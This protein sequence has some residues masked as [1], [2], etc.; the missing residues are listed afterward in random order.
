MENNPK[1]VFKLA[2]NE[3]QLKKQPKMKI[4]EKFVVVAVVQSTAGNKLIKVKQMQLCFFLFSFGKLI[5]I[6]YFLVIPVKNCK[7]NF[8]SFISYLQNRKHWSTSSTIKFFKLF[9]EK[10]SLRYSFGL[11]Y[12]RL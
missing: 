3:E 6:P 10:I 4:F 12:L 9:Y 8:Y 11:R 1:I 5:Y 7:K 2:Q